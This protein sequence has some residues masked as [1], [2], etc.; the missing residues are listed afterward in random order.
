MSNR[1]LPMMPWY[2]D[3]FEASTRAYRYA[4]RCAYRAL[5]EVQWQIGVLPDELERLAGAIGCPLAEFQAVWPVVGKKFAPV[6]GGLQNFR[7]EQH[8]LA[9]LKRKQ[10]HKAAADATN[11]KRTAE[12]DAKRTANRDGER[13]LGDS[14]SVPLAATLGATPLSPSPSEEK[15][16]L[17]PRSG[18]SHLNGRNGKA[19]PRAL[20]TNPRAV[21]DQAAEEARWQ[22]LRERAEE[23][24]F[25]APHPADTP[26]TYE[27]SLR[28]F[29][30][31]FRS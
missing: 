23:C 31:E 2:P 24:G 26:E 16:P 15:N 13:A 14:V 4:E 22:P 17:P 20:G 18:G 30:R 9:A 10:K 21:A 27:T 29:E 25:R 28:I 19:N 7:L 8:R 3:Q 5:L 12:R 11:A 6:E 1:E